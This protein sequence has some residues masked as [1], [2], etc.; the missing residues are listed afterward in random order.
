MENVSSFI[1]MDLVREASKIP[2]AVH[3][4]VGQP[5]LSPS[6]KVLEAIQRAAGEN[7]MGYTPS[8]GIMELREKIAAYYV[9]KYGV[10]I[11]PERIALTV[12]TSGGF[13]TAYSILLNAGDKLAFSD[14]GYPCYRNFSYL[15]DVE[16]V[17]IPVDASTNYQITVEHLKQR[18][19]IKAV[20]ISSPANPTGNV[21]ETQNLK[22]LAEYCEQK[23][24]HF[25]SD[26]LYHGLVYDGTEN[27][28][29][30]FSDN[31]IVLNGFSKY[32]C[33]PGL[34]LG[35]MI[36]PEDKVR[37]AEKV[38]QNVFL[39]APTL[40]QYGALEAFDAEHLEN[41]KR[42]Y[43]ERRDFLYSEL[44]GIFKID[45]VPQG[46]FYLWADASRYTD[47]S[48]ELAEKILKKTGVAVTP[49]LD[50]GKNNTHHYL[51]F[52]YTR[53]IPHMAEGVKRLKEFLK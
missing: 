6:P 17:F 48:L 16:P 53:E 21:Y 43:R 36:L 42:T 35:W 10:N 23:G 44:A 26:E 30:E 37:D 9:Q 3:F 18:P 41:V 40:S 34:R 27:T 4:E 19:D 32:F 47:N 29:L 15:L 24:I 5:D 25:I 28:A 46:A 1:V 49:G 50:F 33:A 22:E 12:G 20:Q 14:P 45:A 11:S 8:L 31:A 52:A 38:I 7:R 13:M 2:D 51:R 39:C